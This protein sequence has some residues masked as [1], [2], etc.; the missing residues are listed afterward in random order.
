MGHEVKKTILPNGLTV[1]SQAL[2]ERRTLSLGAWVRSGARDEPRELLGVTHFLEHMMFKGT[3]RRDARAIASSLESLGGSLDAFTTREHVCYTARVLSEHLPQAV[4]VVSDLVC[5]SRFEA[6]EIEREKSVVREEI[7]AYEDN[8]DEKVA[9][10]LAEQLWGDH[11]LGRPILG[12][13]E[14]VNSLTREALRGQF[15]RRFRG[16]QLVVVAAGG[17]EHEQL[18]AECERGFA[19]PSGTAPVLDAAPAE[20]VPSVR[21]EENELQ[22]LYLSLGA[23]GLGYTDP[24]R[25]ALVVGETLLGG[26]MSSRLFQRIREDAGLA[27]SVFTSIELLRDGGSF[28]VHLGVSPEKGRE[29]LRL[30]REELDRVVAE[31]PGADEVE[32]AK[33][34]LK[35]S[36]VMAQESVS[37]RMYHVA[38][39]ELYL[40]RFMSS[41]TQVGRILAVTRDEVREALARYARP[42]RFSLTALGPAP[43]GALTTADWP[44]GAGA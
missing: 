12:T 27:Y 13:I 25:Y 22:Q 3:Q 34:Q 37:S 20:H 30:L 23:R 33:M 9:D 10:L 7:L 26:G 5:A 42:E 39:Q 44:V 6:G 32:A 17:L 2:P 29:A 19:T 15:E 31:G 14:T 35:G 41:E 40:G 38:R 18:V 1:I 28:A 8:P 4:D 16:D 43:G 36:V 24:M 11:A 21:H